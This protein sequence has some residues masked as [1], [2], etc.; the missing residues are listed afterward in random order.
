MKLKTPLFLLLSALS[1]TTAAQK[2]TPSATYVDDKQNLV[3][4]SEDISEQAPLAVS[5]RANPED[6]GEHTPAY[7]WHIRR[8]GA[9][10]DLMVRYE[11]DTQYTFNESGTFNVVLK[12]RLTD[13]DV[14]LDS[15]TI[16]V[17]ISESRLEMPNA[18]SP[19]GDGIND[20]YGAKGVNDPE[21]TSHYR[22]IVSFH[23]WIFNRWGQKLY[24]WTDVGG[25]W[26]G[27]FN[28]SP[29]KDG[30]YYVLVKAKGADGRE[31]NIRKD[32]NLLRGYTLSGSTTTE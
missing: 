24:E 2:V 18:F 25:S 19:N 4:K 21:S 27:T 16:K 14:D 1:L 15:A 32:V 5:F 28:G 30:V 29:V 9:T 23:A 10:Q 6:M 22:S 12:T 20:R 7:E 31:Y 26:D 8:E 11:E 13:C 3:E 17:T